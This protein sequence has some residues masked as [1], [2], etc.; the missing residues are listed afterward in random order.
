MKFR[1]KG[2]DLEGNAITEDIT[3]PEA[4]ATV[5]GR[6]VFGAIYEVTSLNSSDE[7]PKSTSLSVVGFKI[8]SSN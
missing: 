7:V 3:G 5:T 1:I 8:P 4:N 2:V 6:K